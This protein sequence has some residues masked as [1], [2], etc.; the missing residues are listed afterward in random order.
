MKKPHVAGYS[1]MLVIL[2]ATVIVFA[3]M[4]ARVELDNLQLRSRIDWVKKTAQR[5]AEGEN[6]LYIYSMKDTDGLLACFAGSSD[7]ENIALEMTDVSADGIRTIAGMPNVRSISF[8][9]DNGVNDETL[10]LLAGCQNLETLELT[11]T[12]VTDAGIAHLVQFVSLRN[13]TLGQ[14][15]QPIL[16]DESIEVLGNLQQLET[17]KLTDGATV[18]AVEELRSRIP[19]CKVEYLT[20]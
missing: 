5:L 11:C 12:E 16:T 17:L 9:S 10:L 3:R 8:S 2:L 4:N 7:V 13:L 6:R 20:D 19:H 18:A 15:R 1:A 14:A